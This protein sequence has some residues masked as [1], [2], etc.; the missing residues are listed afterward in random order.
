LFYDPASGEVPYSDSYNSSANFYFAS[1]TSEALR[2][3]RKENSQLKAQLSQERS[4]VKQLTVANSQLLDELKS[5]Y[6]DNHPLQQQVESLTGNG[7]G[8]E[9]QFYYKQKAVYTL[10]HES[11]E[12]KWPVEQ[13]KQESIEQLLRHE[14]GTRETFSGSNLAVNVP[15]GCITSDK[16]LGSEGGADGIVTPQELYRLATVIEGRWV[17]FALDLAPDLFQ[18]VGNISTIQRDLNYASARVKAQAMLETWRNNMDTGATC[19]LLIEALCRDGM[20]KQACDIFGV[21]ITTEQLQRHEEETRETF[22]GSNLAV[23]VPDG[24]I[25]SDKDLGSEGGADGIVTPQELYRLATVIEGRWVEFALDL[26]PDLFQVVGNISTIQRDLNY[27]SA[28]VKAQAM[29]ETWRN[30]MDTGATC[31]LLI[32][33]LC[34]DGMRKQA[35]DIFG[36]EITTAVVPL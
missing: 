5:L 35:C 27:A 17:E 24:C 29:L 30:N 25:T 2:Q 13:R 9:T 34:R 36:V 18:V 31:R 22:S 14:E 33:A 21:E 3:L 23:N 15:D 20:R 6:E 7:R 32:E 12:E 26:A 8:K 1:S 19:R 10:H 16:D 28:R 11:E 4:S